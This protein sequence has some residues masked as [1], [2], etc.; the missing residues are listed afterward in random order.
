MPQP[1]TTGTERTFQ[2]EAV[3]MKI[4]EVQMPSTP[5]ATAGAATLNQCFGQVTSESLTTAAASVY[6]LTVTNSVV[7]TTDV[8]FATVCNGTNTTGTPNIATVTPGAGILTI[9][10]QNIHGSVAFGGT[11]KIG[12]MVVKKAGAPL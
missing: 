10:V 7:T 2:N 5:A 6:T 8:A 4:L 3:R 12:F 9:V 1:G 11:L